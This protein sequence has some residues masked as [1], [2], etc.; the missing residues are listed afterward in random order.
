MPSS[1]VVIRFIRSFNT[2]DDDTIVTIRRIDTNLFSLRMKDGFQ[3]NPNYISIS[4]NTV[5]SDRNLFLWLRIV[6]RL[7]EKDSEP[8]K[9]IQFDMPLMP[10]VLI[11]INKIDRAYHTILDALEF[12]M[13]N[14]PIQNWKPVDEYADMP[15]LVPDENVRTTTSL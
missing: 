12:H 13:D 5:I 4:D 9:G 8:F 10:S 7:V 1:N 6:L 11:H 14:W 15:A 2:K 3:S